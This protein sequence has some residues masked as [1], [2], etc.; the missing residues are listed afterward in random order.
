MQTPTDLDPPKHVHNLVLIFAFSVCFIENKS[1]FLIHFFK[2][3][4]IKLN[5][6]LRTLYTCVEIH[7]PKV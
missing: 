1:R 2:N 6:S 7:V 3:Y 4:Q 5:Y